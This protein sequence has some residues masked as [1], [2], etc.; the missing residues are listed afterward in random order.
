MPKE[1]ACPRIVTTAP[2]S[3]LGAEEVRSKRI[4]HQAQ[5]P[6]ETGLGHSAAPVNVTLPLSCNQSSR[7][8]GSQKHKRSVK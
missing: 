1:R 7:K 3:Q 4:K 5:R 2:R 6:A 8:I